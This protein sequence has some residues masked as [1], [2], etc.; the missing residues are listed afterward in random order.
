MTDSYDEYAAG[1]RVEIE[2]W[3][4]GRDT[5]TVVGWKQV[6]CPVVISDPWT[7]RAASPLRE[8]PIPAG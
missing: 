7:R 1:D 5:V 8:A 3:D 4:G 6:W 2:T